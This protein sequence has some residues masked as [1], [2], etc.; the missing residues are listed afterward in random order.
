[1]SSDVFIP[2]TMAILGLLGCCL[3]R[4]YHTGLYKYRPID[5]GKDTIASGICTSHRKDHDH[6]RRRRRC[7]S[8]FSRISGLP[9]FVVVI[10]IGYLITS[11]NELAPNKV[12][13][14]SIPNPE[15]VEVA[16]AKVRG[17]S[18]EIGSAKVRDSSNKE[19]YI[20]ASNVL[21]LHALTS[22]DIIESIQQQHQRRQHRHRYLH[23][24]RMSTDNNNN[25][26]DTRINNDTED[27]ERDPNIP[28]SLR[29]LTDSTGN[30]PAQLT[31]RTR[32]GRTPATA[33]ATAL[34]TNLTLQ[35]VT[36]SQQSRRRSSSAPTTNSNRGPPSPLSPLNPRN[37][38]VAST[39]TAE[40]KKA[41]FTHV[42][43]SVFALTATD[44][45]YRGLIE[46]GL[47]TIVD[48]I[49]ITDIT[50]N[51]ITYR[52][53]SGNNSN[54]LNVQDKGTLYAFRQWM[55]HRRANG[56]T[57]ST[58]AEWTALTNEDF[59][60]YRSGDY[61]LHNTTSGTPSST[62]GNRFTKD[63][64]ADR[65]KSIKRDATLFPVHL[66]S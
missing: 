18:V 25:N 64:V 38:S 33:S 53:T 17:S 22:R 55:A 59:E 16:S 24:H 13:Q 49:S 31:S 35:N 9:L 3:L 7:I 44:T 47:K 50:I 56:V 41:A 27:S 39:F 46:S 15:K 28:P 34:G 45:L 26:N 29:T 23:E 36:Q 61:L 4:Q 20:G 65:L 37:M 57:T 43:T 14:T 19:H 51:G 8:W 54:N 42:L 1:M 11:V 12:I 2:F 30:L 5:R 40:D 21:H 48:L 63:P 32:S 6:G 10:G 58:L 60:A 62:S 66:R 52:T